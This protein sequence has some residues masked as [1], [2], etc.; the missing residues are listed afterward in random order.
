MLV[1]VL[2][3]HYGRVL[4]AG[5]LRVVRDGGSFAARY[6]EHEL[7]LSPRTLDDLLAA[8]AKR[9]GSGELAEIADAF[10]RLP[11]A[12]V[13]EAVAARHRD[14]EMLRERLA[15]LC[16]GDE[17]LAAVV[18]AEVEDL[19]ATVDA[20]DTLL[21]RQNRPARRSTVGVARCHPRRRR[22]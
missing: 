10:G 8:A 17:G 2:S 11:H 9:A 16:D 22:G 5:N 14:K 21:R 6:H 19:N 3:D 20:L 15:R 4:E 1:P 7:P 12:R 13:T 18:D